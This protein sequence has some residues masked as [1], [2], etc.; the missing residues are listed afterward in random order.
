MN[1]GYDSE[2]MQR[3]I[4]VTLNANLIVPTRSG[5]DTEHAWEKYRKEMTK[6]FD[7][8]RYRKL[9]LIETSSLSS[10]GDSGLT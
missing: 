4:R 9:F 2:K 7:S 3:Y 5:K 10:N 1:W 8:N 6:N